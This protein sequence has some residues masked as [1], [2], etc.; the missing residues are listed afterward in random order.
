MELPFSNIAPELNASFAAARNQ[1]VAIAAEQL[2]IAAMGGEI[3][4]GNDG[5]AFS[6][7]LSKHTDDL[8]PLPKDEDMVA[9]LRPAP[10]LGCR[11]DHP[12]L[13]VV[14]EGEYGFVRAS[15]P[16]VFIGSPDATTC[17][18][19]AVRLTRPGEGGGP[20]VTA[21]VHLNDPDGGVHQV[22]HSM[23]WEMAVPGLLANSPRTAAATPIIA[24]WYVVGAMPA[25][26]STETVAAVFSFFR[27]MKSQPSPY[28]EHRGLQLDHQLCWDGVCFLRM[29][30]S[31]NNRCA[32]WGIVLDCFTGQCA[33]LHIEPGTR[34]YPAAAL[35]PAIVGYR[36][37]SMLY[38]GKKSN[39]LTV[40]RGV[41]DSTLA[42]ALDV[43]TALQ[44]VTGGLTFDEFVKELDEAVQKGLRTPL[45]LFRTKYAR[46]PVKKA[47]SEYLEMS[48]SPQ[49]EPT[50]FG[51][52]LQRAA[53]FASIFSPES[54]FRSPALLL[55]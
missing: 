23:L 49:C 47:L 42:K 1:P 24:Q 54:V 26:V 17:L 32:T 30:R 14:L 22:L 48:T 53:I 52:V 3:P 7:F 37:I 27:S 35:R 4:T 20:V 5:K 38:R 41:A 29:N 19:V 15:K 44:L 51:A 9:H 55:S 39:P 50:D 21:L 36:P 34:K 18:V 10:G 31:P 43:A 25:K 46:I 12:A 45:L 28:P 11:G 16:G 2:C 6:H 40:Q 33:P 8:P 13:T